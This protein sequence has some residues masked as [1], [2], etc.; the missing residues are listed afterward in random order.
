MVKV[1]ES[2]KEKSLKYNLCLKVK[3]DMMAGVC[4]F[5][6]LKYFV[7]QMRKIDF[8]FSCDH[9]LITRCMG[10]KCTPLLEMHAK[11]LSSASFMCHE[12]HET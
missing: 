8:Q 5:L 4:N 1:L 7:R 11:K 9:E 10:I 6:E 2:N 12:K 3:F